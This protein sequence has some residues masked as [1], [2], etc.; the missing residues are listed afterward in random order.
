MVERVPNGGAS[1]IYASLGGGSGT[2]VVGG[3]ELCAESTELAADRRSRIGRTTS[4][5]R[6]ID[7]IVNLFDINALFPLS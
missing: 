4:L 2:E 6:R 5:S 3:G 1:Q 7:L